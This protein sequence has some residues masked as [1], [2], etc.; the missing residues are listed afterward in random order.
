M[1]LKKTVMMG[2][3]LSSLMAVGAGA[4]AAPVEDSIKDTQNNGIAFYGGTN[5]VEIPLKDS[6][7]PNANPFGLVYQGAITKNEK[8]KV[9]IHPVHYNLNGNTI[10]ANIYTPA[11][12][13]KTS[14]K[15][16]AAI[17]VAHPNGGVKEQVA[18]LYAQKLAEEG[19]ITIAADASFQGASGGTPH[20][21]DNPAFRTED[22]HGMVDVIASYSG[23]DDSRIGALGICG[24]GGY[25][26]KATQTDKRVKAV[27]TLSMFNSGIVRRNGFMNSGRDTIQKRLLESSQQR[28]AEAK[29]AAIKRTV[30]MET[31]EIPEEELKKMPTLYREGYIYYG[32]THRHPNSTFQY[33]VRSNLDLFTFD[34]ADNMD[35]I[36]QP[37]LMIAGDKADTLYMTEDAF[38]KATGTNNKELYLVKGAT[39]IQTYWVPKYVN[40]IEG[41]LASFYKAN[42]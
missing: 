23:V 38:K 12:Y 19:Y 22:I 13:D 39:H 17:V 9:N 14:S 34:A 36:N 35:L 21:L 4:Y 1:K 11:G 7:S 8:G 26:L 30:G 16:Y 2:L 10:A 5:L 31:Q 42:L 3:V 28:A 29:G 41:K 37:L 20:M 18:G 25:T 33:T 6:K 32:K 40:E 15:K 24:G 27:A